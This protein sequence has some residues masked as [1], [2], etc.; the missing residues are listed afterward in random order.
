MLLFFQRFGEIDYVNVLRDKHSGENK[1]FA[2]VKYFRRVHA[3]K[4]FEECDRC[5][6][7]QQMGNAFHCVKTRGFDNTL[8]MYKNHS[9]F[10]NCVLVL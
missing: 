5:K 8:P 10:C 7:V 4:A 3:A 1:G 9:F 6:Y 2:Y